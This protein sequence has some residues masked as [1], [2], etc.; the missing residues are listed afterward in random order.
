MLLKSGAK[1]WTAALSRAPTGKARLTQ[2]CLIKEQL[3]WMCAKKKTAGLRA[4]VRREEPR[5]ILGQHTPHHTTHL[6]TK[7]C[8]VPW[9][10]WCL[11]FTIMRSH[12]DAQLGLSASTHK[13]IPTLQEVDTIIQHRKLSNSPCYG[14]HTLPTHSPPV[15]LFTYPHL[16]SYPHIH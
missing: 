1:I 16:L 13:T 11:R 3:K 4:R 9:R 10:G 6:R 8:P 15:H 2:K 7:P 5:H 14:S 12:N